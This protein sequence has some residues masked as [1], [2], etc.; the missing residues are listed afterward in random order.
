LPFLEV[1]RV[2]W[3]DHQE[4]LWNMLAFS[5]ILERL[6]TFH[7]RFHLEDFKAFPGMDYIHDSQIIIIYYSLL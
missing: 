3:L 7:S 5:G 4:I 2:P 6:S 1:S